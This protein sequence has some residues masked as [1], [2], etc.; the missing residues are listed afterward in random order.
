MLNGEQVGFSTASTARETVP[1]ARFD[2][3]ACEEN[4]GGPRRP[5]ETTWAKPPSARYHQGMNSIPRLGLLLPIV[6]LALPSPLPANDDFQTRIQPLLQR[7][8]IRCHNA[9]EMQSGIRVDRLNG[10][11][12]DRNLRLW[13]AIQGQVGLEAMP[14][15]DQP[16]PSDA[17]RVLLDAWITSALNTARTRPRPN[18]GTVRRLTVAQYRNTLRDL[19]GVDDDFTDILPPDASSKDGFTNH[20][21]TLL[22]SPLLVEAYFEIAEKALSAAIVAEDS[23]PTIQNFRMDLGDG[24]NPHPC[25]DNLILGA[26]SLLLP[27]DDFVV[28]ELA[29]PRPFAY[30]PF[31]MR[32]HYRFNEGYQGNATVRGWR[33]FDSI[34]HSVFAC[35][36]GDR[37]YPKGL[38]Y[39]SCNEGLLLRPAIPTSGL[40]GQSSTYGPKANFKVSLRE[41]PEEGRFRIKVTAARY[42]DALL[43]E[44]HAKPQPKEAAT[45]VRCPLS[46][47]A[48]ATLAAPEDGIYQIDLDRPPH[49]K[50]VPVTIEIDG[51]RFSTQLPKP[52]S[53]QQEAKLVRSAVMVVRLSQ[54]AHQVRVRG[55]NA[56]ALVATRLAKGSELFADFERFEQRTPYLGV[57][58][59][60]RRDCGSTVAPVGPPQPVSDSQ[61]RE[62]VFE[63]AINN[64]PSPDV[65][66]NNINYLAGV[67]EFAVRH[68]YTDGRD[69]PRLL[70]R[71][72]EFEGPL[73][74]TWP[75]RSH[76]KIFIESPNRDKRN[77]AYARE[78]LR[79][80]ATNAYRRPLKD[81]EEQT[82]VDVWKQSREDG[83]DFQQ[84]VQ[85]ALLVALTSPQFL[86]LIED[87]QSPQDEPLDDWELAS[88]LSYFLWNRP[89]D[90][91]LRTLAREGRLRASL[92][93]Q[94]DRMVD[95]PRF[96]GF[97]NDFT[98]QWL[99]LDKLDVVEID[100]KRMPHLTRE[101]RRHLRRE[102]VEY[103]RRLIDENLPLAALVR[104]DFIVA[105]DPVAS[106]YGLKSETGLA[107]RPLPHQREHLGGLLSQAGI[108]AGLSDGR[109]SNPV[110]RGAWLARKI[111]AKPPADPP[112]NVPELEE[113]EDAE[114]TLRERLERH[115][116]QP[117]CAKCHEGIDPWGVPFEQFDASGLLKPTAVDAGSTLPDQT[118]VAGLAELK[119]HLATEMLDDVAFS[120]LK[121]VAVY[122]SGRTL[123][124][125]EIELLKQKRLE[126]KAAGYPV[127]DMLRFVVQ[128]DMF[129]TK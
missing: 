24:I 19:L 52:T 33:E 102:P 124:Y 10:Q 65:E 43:L 87:S 86:F 51:R 55:G 80:F 88:K 7:Y 98:P 5:P 29:P 2:C 74:E 11:L 103:L 1:V 66:E 70:I 117:G 127:R 3:A 76:R 89:P 95:D 125:R 108:L 35:V 39:E 122:A 111:I 6:L 69:L 22:L 104:S 15:E 32:T 62:F 23:L 49:D 20:D 114:L 26:N 27:N 9:D 123:N 110:K 116:N 96:D 106:Y 128:S 25:P 100:P 97:L 45:Q 60:L 4:N 57:H 12:E 61:W 59:G 82:L 93:S 71:S 41:L 91:A 120:F 78:V 44:R 92:D 115:R 94:F 84:S 8:C 47:D 112:P 121:H 83:R 31:Q 73:Y 13:E 77:E 109:E 38:P 75:P 79:N 56:Q 81:G 99:Q 40:F 118:E 58:L 63:G 28:K 17:E 119:T 21:K 129:L 107:Y 126:L 72:V 101:M 37:G 67:R 54:G 53:K 105:N 30:A 90:D 34:Y 36:R 42:Q 113:D 16:Q 48:T 85:D 64:F 46:G 68:E 18:H 50:P 14:P